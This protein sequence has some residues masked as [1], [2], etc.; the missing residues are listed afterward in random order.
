MRVTLEAE[1]IQ[2]IAEAVVEAIRP[3]LSN[4]NKADKYMTMK[5]LAAYT[6]LAYSTIANN[7]KYLPHTYLNGTP[8]FKQSEIDEYLSRFRV[9]A[10][11]KRRNQRFAELF[12]SK[13]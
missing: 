8:L 7:K 3:M 6:G 2:T 11:E 4:G 12:R 5:E 13:R 1:D 10:K 9:K